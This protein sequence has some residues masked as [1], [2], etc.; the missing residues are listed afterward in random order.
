MNSNTSL[1]TVAEF[2]KTQSSTGDVGSV[3]ADT[4]VGF[5]VA[6]WIIMAVGAVAMIIWLVRIAADILLIVTRGLGKGGEGEG[7]GLA[8]F[9]T[10]K[11]ESYETVLKYLKGNF[12]E[13]LLVFILITFLIT[14]WLFTIVSLAISGIGTLGNKLLGL[15]IGG[16][17]S[18][19]DAEAFRE[20]IAS[21]R[22]TSLRKQY[23][24]QLASAKQ[25]SAKLY[26]EMK[27]GAIGDDPEMNQIKSFYTQAM[28]KADLLGEALENRD[29]RAE[30]KLSEG[31]FQQHLRQRGEGI[32]N[33]S[34]LNSDVQQTFNKNISCK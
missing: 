4:A 13:I 23:D 22:N 29:A 19:L 30:F 16:K 20:N 5:K 18:A 27:N 26:D 34:F 8:R 32:C 33:S 28:V 14:G 9:G 2:F 17:L 11:S 31:Y 7:G 12:I 6:M 15:D 3:L 10:G 25:Y 1:S 21:Q 24:E